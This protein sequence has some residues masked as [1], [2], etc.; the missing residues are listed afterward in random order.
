MDE[1]SHVLHFAFVEPAVCD[2]ATQRARETPPMRRE[3]R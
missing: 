3:L 2:E 1:C